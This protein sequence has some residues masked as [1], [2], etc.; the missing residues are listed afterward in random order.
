MSALENALTANFRA[1]ALSVIL[2][3]TM[4]ARGGDEDARRW[5]MEGEGADWADLLDLPQWP[6][7]L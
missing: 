3:A 1:L 2:R 4:D 5:L 7:R 6:P